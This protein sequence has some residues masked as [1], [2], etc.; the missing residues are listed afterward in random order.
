MAR[1][2]WIG[3]SAL[4]GLAACAG[5]DPGVRTVAGTTA[6]ASCAAAGLA[7][8]SQP[9]ADC[10]EALHRNLVYAPPGT[11]R[12]DL[13]TLYYRACVAGGRPAAPCGCLM[14]QL[15]AN[16][17]TDDGLRSLLVKA[18][19]IWPPPGGQ[20]INLAPIDN[21]SVQCKMAFP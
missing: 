6:E 8:G 9:F 3:M 4:L 21:A 10:V 12:G 5:P 16:G 17:L 13:N 15:K 20:F 1:L 11:S 7:A 18:R 19:V 14:N 2:A